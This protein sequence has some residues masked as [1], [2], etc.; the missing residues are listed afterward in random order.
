M[1]HESTW[2]TVHRRPSGIFR[3]VDLGSY[4]DC[5]GIEFTRR[6]GDGAF[7]IWRNTFP[8][9]DLPRGEIVD[10]GGVPFC[11]PAAD[12]RHPDNLRCRGQRI[13]LP[14]GRVDW[15]CFLAA[16]ERR[17]EDTLS[18][19]YAD[20][21]T[22][23]QWLRVSDFWPETPPRFGDV[24]AFRTPYLLYQRHAQS[25]MAPAIWRQRVPVTIPGDVAAVTLPENPA[26]HIFALTLLTEEE[27]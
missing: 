4:A 27:M 26:M 3:T 7:N 8:A 25:G 17:T 2:A 19:H 16:A 9:E 22:R 5:V 15:L 21:A 6:P 13:E 1:S 14:V 12:G 20:G 24:L 10:V 18:V 11:F 23:A